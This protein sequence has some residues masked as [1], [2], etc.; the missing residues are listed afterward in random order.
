[1]D[2]T[3]EVV[4][5][6]IQ[7]GE[8][9]P[10]DFDDAWRW[11]G[12]TQKKTALKKLRKHFDKGVDYIGDDSDESEDEV[13]LPKGKA[14]H[15]GHNRRVIFL[16]IEC[17]KSFCMMAGTIKGKEVRRYF[18]NCE[19]ELKRLLEQERSRWQESTQKR[20]VEA[21]VSEEVVSR[22]PKF[23]DEFYELLYKKRGNGWE[24]RDP[25]KNRPACVGT[26]TNWTVYDRLLGGTDPGGVKEALNEVNPRI[27]GRRKDRHHWH[28]KGLGE[29]HLSSQLEV[30]KAVARLSPDGNWDKFMRN[31][32]KA[33]PNGEALQLNLLDMLEEI[34]PEAS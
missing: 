10:V 31:I 3:P 20:L 12:Y 11:T 19:R 21:M 2:L 24:N 26:W 4:F 6:L 33:C 7:S 8:E 1:M 15:G 9:F 30:V 13:A 29:F 18:L 16:S 23:S 27:D 5:S 28:L 17:F 22:K 25:K 32:Q 34:E 14:S